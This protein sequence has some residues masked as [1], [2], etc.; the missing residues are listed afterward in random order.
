MAR[1][2]DRSRGFSGA[3]LLI[4][5]VVVAALAAAGFALLTMDPRGTRG[6]RTGHRY[7]ETVREQSRLDPS[8]L[9]WREQL[10]PVDLEMEEPA[11]IAVGTD[12]RIYV[13]GDRLVA[14][15]A[16][17]RMLTRSDPLGAD[18]RA[19][20][21]DG[22]GAIF[23]VSPAGVDRL[24]IAG[25]DVRVLGSRKLAADEDVFPTAVGITSE[26]VFVAEAWGGR[27]LRF[28]A[29][30]AEEKSAPEEPAVLASGFN[31]PSTMDLCAHPSGDLVTIDPGRHQVQLRDRYGDVV[32][33][34]GAMGGDIEDFHGCCNP[35]AVAVL[36]DGRTV[37]AEKGLGVT[38]VKVHDTA[39]QLEGVVAGPDSF[40]VDPDGPPLV[41]DLAVD[42]RGRILVLD[43]SRR[44]VRIF[45]PRTGAGE[46]ESGR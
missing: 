31:V 14:L 8:K 45:V 20:A 29:F 24:E 25:R 38:R 32:R 33:R 34:W 39:G 46:P 2:R 26:G 41:L 23:A 17:G 1:S 40:D 22:G 7:A 27:V 42:S 18:Y 9:T 6:P 28:P 30:G 44:Q 21:V 11:G 15:S 3:G 5:L 35:V 37:T 16:A 43:P 13:I 12:D 4:A 19:L 10:P 36:A